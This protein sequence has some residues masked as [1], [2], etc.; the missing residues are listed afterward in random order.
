MKLSPILWLFKLSGV[1]LKE[2]RDLRTKLRDDGFYYPGTRGPL[3][4]NVA[5]RGIGHSR[6]LNRRWMADIISEIERAGVGE[7]ARLTSGGGVSG[8][9]GGRQADQ[10][11]PAPGG[12][13]ADRRGPETERVGANH[14]PRIWF[15]G[16][17]V[18]GCDGA[19]GALQ[20]GGQR[21][22]LRGGEVTGDKADAIIR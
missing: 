21:C 14:Y 18:D 22:L 6:P 11:G 4:K 20:L 19:R 5:R 16:S 13:C 15:I 8:T 10:S 3:S 12:A 7:R 1:C 9:R 2:V 17:G